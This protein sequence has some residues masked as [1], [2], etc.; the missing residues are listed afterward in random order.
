MAIDWRKR[1]ADKVKT[2]ADAVRVI[3]PGQRVYVGSACGEP[4]ELVRALA[5]HG[6]NLADT[7]IVHILTFGVAPYAQAKFA[8]NFRANAF[9]IGNSVRSAVNEARADYTP[10]FL[11][12]VPGLFRSRRLGI[13]VALVMVSP[14]DDY[15]NC[16]LGVSVD[17]T[18]AAVESA[19]HVISQVNR[20]MPR[21][22]GDCFINV[23]N[24][25]ALV[26]FD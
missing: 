21:A 13:D 15:G 25:Q 24:I 12:Q 8:Q 7:E 10:V 16:S 5:A 11:S 3:R 22:L 9:F 1:Y 4:Q 19:R 20:F 2:A 23:R 26:P 6:E 18:K 17:I 14:P